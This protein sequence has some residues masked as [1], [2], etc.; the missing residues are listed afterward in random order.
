MFQSVVNFFRWTWN[1]PAHAWCDKRYQWS[2]QPMSKD[3]QDYEK[4]WIKDDKKRVLML[5]LEKTNRRNNLNFPNSCFWICALRINYVD[6]LNSAPLREEVFVFKSSLAPT[7]FYILPTHK[8]N[9]LK[10]L[11]VCQS[12][13]LISDESLSSPNNDTAILTR[14]HS[15]KHIQ[16]IRLQRQQLDITDLRRRF[17]LKKEI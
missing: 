6:F 12:I 14:F 7:H 13:V 9:H 3:S 1:C 4:N 17:L 11:F 8:V 2:G 16:Y 5:C 10:T 15:G